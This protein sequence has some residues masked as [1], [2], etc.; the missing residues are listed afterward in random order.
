[1]ATG[2]LS[3]LATDFSFLS[4][5]P[6]LVP[7]TSHCGHVFLISCNV[8][9]HPVMAPDD[10]RT[11][12]TTRKPDLRAS[13]IAWHIGR[14]RF[15]LFFPPPVLHLRSAR[16]VPSRI[17]ANVGSSLQWFLFFARKRTLSALAYMDPRPCPSVLASPIVFP[18][19]P[20]GN[21]VC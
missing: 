11:P 1:V 3:L 12:G 19:S 8:S 2:R 13:Y 9:Q 14:R 20:H 10:L 15:G 17:S 21:Q 18:F 4:A 16:V 6:P 7:T 5:R